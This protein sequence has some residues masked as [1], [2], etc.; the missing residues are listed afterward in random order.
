MKIA[1]KDGVRET[2]G[3]PTGMGIRDSLLAAMLAFGLVVAVFDVAF[4][5]WLRLHAPG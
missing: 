3:P 4:Y 1:S 5:V 2:G